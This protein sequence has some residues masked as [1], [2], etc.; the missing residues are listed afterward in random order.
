MNATAL[1]FGMLSY[2]FIIIPFFTGDPTLMLIAPFCSL[3]GLVFGVFALRNNKSGF[4][5][6]LT[7]LIVALGIYFVA[8]VMF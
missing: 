4:I 7:S 2:L 5:C 1:V 8:W 3:L 6:C